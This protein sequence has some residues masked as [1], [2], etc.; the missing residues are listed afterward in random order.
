MR[1]APHLNGTFALII[2][3]I[4]MLFAIALHRTKW[5]MRHTRS[6]SSSCVIADKRCYVI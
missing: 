2:I 5:K 4:I 6:E 1:Y 3:S